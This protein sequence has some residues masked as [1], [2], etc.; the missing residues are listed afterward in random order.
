MPLLIAR[1]AMALCAVVFPTSLRWRNR[2][3]PIGGATRDRRRPESEAIHGVDPR[4]FGGARIF[5]ARN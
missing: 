2:I 4:C 1:I 5:R 3:K